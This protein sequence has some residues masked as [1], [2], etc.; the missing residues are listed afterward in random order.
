MKK[1]LFSIFLLFSADIVFAQQAPTEILNGQLVAVTPRLST[2]QANASP[3]PRPKKSRQFGENDIAN[4]RVRFPIDNKNANSI[5]GALQTG[6]NSINVTPK[7]PI[8]SFDGV[9]SSDNVTLFGSTFIPPDPVLSVGPN[10]IVQM[11]NSAHRVY[12]KSGTSLAGPIKFSSIVPGAGDDGDPITLY[13]HV[14]DRWLLLQFDLPGGTNNALIFCISQTNDPTGAYNVYRFVTSAS[15]PDYPHVGIWNNSYIVTTHE[16]NTAGTAYLGQGFYAMDR[17]K[18][19]DGLSGV[20]GIRFQT[21]SSEG[22]YLPMSMEGMKTPEAN[23]LPTFFT[24]D[25]DELGAASDRLIYR[26]LSPDFTTPSNSVLSAVVNLNTSAFDGRSPS[27]RSAIEQSGTTSGLDAINDRMMSRIIYRRFDNHESVVMNHG[28]NVSGAAAGAVT[29]GTFTSAMRWYELTRANPTDPWTINQQSTF[30]P[31]STNGATGDNRWMG[32]P[33]IDQRGNIAIGY[34]ISSSSTFPSLNYAERKRTDPLSTL[35]TEQVL[36]AGTGSQTSGNRWGDY[37]AMTTDPTDEETLW[38]TGEYYGVTGTFNFRTRVGSFKVTDPISTPTVHFKFGGTIARQKDAS[39]NPSIDYPI[40]I[41]ID[42]AP[43]QPVL[44]TLSSSGTATAGVDYDLINAAPFT[45]SSGTLTKTIILRVYN[46]AAIGE[47]SEFLNLAYTLNPNGGDAIAGAYNQKHRVTF[48]G[49]SICPTSNAVSNNRPLTFCTGDST[50]LSAINVAGY[51][52]Q[53]KRNNTIISGATQFQYV[54]KESGSYV[55]EITNVGCTLTSSPINVVVNLG[56]PPPATVSRTIAFGTTITPGNGLQAS[57]NCAAENTQTYAGGVVGYD[58]GLSSGA[59]PTVSF[60]GIGT[61]TGKVKVAITWRK[62]SG[63]TQTSCGTADAGTNPFNNEVSFRL[64][65]PTGTIINL[66]NASTYAGGGTSAGT[67]ITTF[68]DGGTALGTIP[69][70]GTFNPAQSLSGF[71]GSDPNGTWT[72]LPNDN[73]NGDPL[74]VSGFVVTVY[75]SGSGG[76]AAISWFANPTGGSALASGT[77][78]I[79]TDTAPGTYTYYAEASCS[80]PGLTGCNPSLRKAATLTITNTCPVPSVGGSVTADATVCTGSNSG[81]LTLSGQTGN[82]IRW[83]SSTDNFVTVTT[84]ANTT[85]SQTY[86]NLTQTTKFRAVV[87]NGTCPIANS[88]AATITVTNG[89]VAGSVTADATVCTGSNS[90]TLTLSGHTGTILRWESST[91]NFVTITTIAN[92]TTSQTYTNLTQTTKY[93][94][95]VQNGTCTAANST[96]ATITVTSVSIGGTVASDATVCSGAN[97]GTLTLSGNSG[98]VVRWESSID[99][100]V[101]V[102]NIANT[103]TS[104]TYTNLT[105]TTQFRAVVQAGTCPAVNSSSATISTTPPSVGGIVTLDASVCSGTNSGTLTLSGNVGNVV[106]WESSTDNF[107]TVT[108]IA[109]TTSSQTYSNLTQSTKFRAV[110]QNGT[111]PTA[112]STAATITVISINATASNT[113]PYAEGATITLNATGGGTYSWSGPNSFTSTANPATISN[114][115]TAMSGVYTVT[116]TQS[117]CSA[118]ATTSVMVNP[119]GVCTVSYDYVTGDNP[120]AYLFP[121]VNNMVIGH[122]MDTYTTIIATPSCNT[123]ES[124]RF[125][126]QGPPPYGNHEMIE[127]QTYYALFSN[128]G[129]WTFGRLLPIGNYTLTTTGYSQDNAAGSVLYGPVVTNFS[130]VANNTS[131]YAP[132]FVETSLCAGSTFYVSFATAGSFGAGNQFQVQLSDKYSSFDEPTVIGTASSAGTVACTIPLNV[133]ESSSY[134]VRVVSTNQ[135]VAGGIGSTALTMNMLNLTLISPNNNYAGGDITKKAT[136]M[137][138]ATNK[139]LSPAKVVYQAGNAVVLRAGFEANANTVFKAEIRG[140]N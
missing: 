36:H 56:T 5:D 7:A 79:P 133:E 115:T 104:Q 37:S 88:S 19:L 86:T 123:I 17:N 65:S 101:N 14:A 43:S 64:Q 69:A 109:N 113:G 18:M 22:G 114:A 8:T 11:V 126:L 67:V 1:F 61:S 45:L 74:C 24:F 30:A 62:K 96:P 72:L 20:T 127:N 42:N 81:T 47:P 132:T 134:K 136:A 78:Y 95:V 51:T 117:S 84:I 50:V 107:S 32:S 122:L 13:D 116:A 70:T 121:L 103:T 130:I 139:I 27:S 55:A 106:R 34:S 97:S 21:G 31:T 128:T 102:T 57:A 33:G 76:A 52:Y 105:Q 112:N 12:N 75:T 3:S 29:I 83:E 125:Q 68:E 41:V 44:V 137:I 77:E 49:V 48:V 82:V 140:C 80:V 60:S 9:V 4:K 100:F 129:S 2:I 39:P 71:N 54:A 135:A 23:S 108:N 35:Q 93:R 59:N 89:T 138:D 118:T 38:Y 87:Q 15:F 25:S 46:D 124:M 73:G 92:T 58:N 99:N 110:I 26:T 98:S 40:D 131:I 91:D 10:H 119:T 6:F 63:G 94:A 111:C 28:V 120:F 16:F 53:W 90:G 85:T 66:I